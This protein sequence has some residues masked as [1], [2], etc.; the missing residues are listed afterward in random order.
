MLD[1]SVLTKLLHGHTLTIDVAL[2]NRPISSEYQRVINDIKAHV[3]TV[4][5]ISSLRTSRSNTP[6]KRPSF[7]VVSTQD[8]IDATYDGPAE[9]DAIIC[10]LLNF[11]KTIQGQDLTDMEPSLTKKTSRA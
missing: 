5:Q 4:R 6:V 8:S 2:D 11:L 3:G 9:N 7:R 10:F 1:G